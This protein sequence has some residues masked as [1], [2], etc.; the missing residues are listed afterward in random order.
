MANVH[1]GNIGDIW[2]HLPLAEILA[3]EAPNTYWESH[4]GSS[5][6][7]LTHS[8]E[9]E[10]GIFYFARA[11]NQS[12]LLS[13]AVYTQLLKG[14]ERNGLLRLYPAGVLPLEDIV[15]EFKN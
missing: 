7:A 3:I 12:K 11:A 9:R 4:A 10:Y 15:G 2:K 8:P 13:H 6:Y 5:H 1:Y 14:Y